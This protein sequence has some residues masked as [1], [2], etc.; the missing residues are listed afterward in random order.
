LGKAASRS[1]RF[2]TITE[3]TY[4]LEELHERGVA[5]RDLMPDNVLVDR[6]GAVHLID[7]DQAAIV[8]PG[9]AR[10]LDFRATAADG[11]HPCRGF[12][13][14]LIPALRLEEEYADIATALRELWR[15][16]ARSDANS[17]GQEIAYYSWTF[18][19]LELRGERP[20]RQRWQ[21]IREVL[22]PYLPDARIL[23]L[24]CNMGMLSLHCLLGGASQ[25]TG[26]DRESDIV[27]CATQ[28]ASIAGKELNGRSG[29]LNDPVFV[30]ELGS[31]SY[32]VAIA[33]SVVHWLENKTPV[34]ELLSRVPVVLFEGHLT[35]S[36]E[37]Q[38]LRNI[39][40]S[41][42]KLIGY[43][44]RLRGLYLARKS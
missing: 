9:A 23:D 17:P 22:L 28:L 41:D 10:A 19:D 20:W 42:V 40:F 1:A 11:V 3:L 44:D 15:R 18:G 8:S 13:R 43:S 32:D 31:A 27:E 24:G 26:V 12:A 34:L 6:Q 7:F 35:P 16:A 36:E 5:H 29:D 33:L 38:G 30:S 14:D 4:L 2:R 39:G 37:M 21:L 25:V